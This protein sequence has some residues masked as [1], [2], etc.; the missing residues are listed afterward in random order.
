MN[1]ADLLDRLDACGVRLWL[2]GER[3]RFCGPRGA[4]SP[5]LRDEIKTL[6]P[7]IAALLRRAP[8]TASQRRLWFLERLAPGNPAL[9]MGG[10]FRL[11]GAFSPDRFQA[12]LD[13][14]TARH[15]ALR[16]SIHDDDGEPY[17]LAAETAHLALERTRCGDMNAALAA[18]QEFLVAPFALDVAPLMR[19]A[20]FAVDDDTHLLGCAVHHLIADEWSEGIVLRELSELYGDPQTVLPDL[21][22]DY[23]EFARSRH[24]AAYGKDAWAAIEARV[25]ALRPPLPVLDLSIAGRRPQR[26]DFEGARVSRVIP[27]AL[28]ARLCALARAEGA[29]PFMAL[30]TCFLIV[31]AKYGGGAD[32]L[33]GT[34]TAGRRSGDEAGL[35]G[36]LADTLLLRA[37]LS[38][39]PSFRE[40]LG[41]VRALCL[42]AYAQGEVAFDALVE[43]L[44]P[45]R[46]SSRA[47]LFQAAI[48]LEN[49]PA[50]ALALRGVDVEAIESPR[51]GSQFD[52]ALVLAERPG[53]MTAMV[54]YA[55]ALFTNSAMTRLLGHYIQVLTVA[56][57]APNDAIRGFDLLTDVEREKLRA[58]EQGPPARVRAGSSLHGLFAAQAALTPRAT[59]L[60]MGDATLSYGGLAARAAVLAAELSQRGVGRGAVV[61]VCLPRGFDLVAAILAVLQVG[62]AYLPLDPDYPAARLA[63]MVGETGAAVILTTGALARSPSLLGM[64][65][66]AEF[67]CVDAEMTAAPA[68]FADDV[69]DGALAGIIYT[70]GSTGTPKGVTLSH[71]GLCN[72]ALEQIEAFAI[73]AQSRVLQFAS[74]SFDAAASEIF[75][76]LL[77]GATL[78]LATR[79]RLLTDLVDLLEDERISVATL[80]PALLQLLP[81]RRL[82]D[83]ATLVVAGEACAP[84][85]ARL[86]V[87]GRRFLN[88][89]GPTEGSVCATIAACDGEGDALPIG[90][91]VA[92]M[93]VRIL[94]DGGRRVPIGVEGEIHLAGLPLSPG[95][96]R[97]PDLTAQRFLP[98]PEAPFGRLYATGDLGAWRE[99]GQIDYRGRRDEQIKLRGM[100]IEPAEIATALRAHPDVAEAAIVAHADE[101]AGMRLTAYVVAR[102]GRVADAHA[103]KRWLRERLPAHMIPAALVRL[104]ALPLS[105]NGKLDRAA[106]PKPQA[107]SGPRSVAPR[108]DLEMRLMRMW[109]A[110]LPGQA[111]GVSDDFF[112]IGGHSLLAV[113]L[114]ALIEERLQRSVSLTTLLTHPTIERLAGEL[115]RERTVG[116]WSPLVE[117]RAGSTA[118]PFFCVHPLGGNVWGYRP[119]AARMRPDQGL[120]ALQAPGLE[121]GS[122][123]C[124]SVEALA[125]LYLSA[126]SQVAP[127]G[128]IHLGGHS[129]GGL[130]AFEMARRWQR[131][132]RRV[133]SLVLM[134][135]PAPIDANRPAA[136]SDDGEWLRRRVRVLEA[137]HG[138]A[139]GVA[140][141]DFDKLEPSARIDLFLA[142]LRRGDLLPEEA[143]EAFVR[144][145]LSVQRA[146]H[147]AATSYRP[148]PTPLYDG[149]ILLL[150]A[151]ARRPEAGQEG[152]ARAFSHP[153]LNWDVFCRG[154]IEAH[155][156]PGDH[157]SMLAEPH[158]A[159]I[160][161][162]LSRYWA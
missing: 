37:D 134:D 79:E 114:L 48:V 69:G 59:A 123:P 4:V 86:W 6:R 23:F 44:A 71:A 154:P 119:L 66:A 18:A 129:F 80:P 12:A 142:A 42:E 15:G 136:V 70:S 25:A 98:D 73:T 103:L 17:Q 162:L 29:T 105:P 45:Q 149:N 135:T 144:R 56:V 157:I 40:L 147:L 68:P 76:A 55:T 74:L 24:R 77:S 95:Y 67:V 155:T 109:E 64:P 78:V 92:G 16:V 158:V 3:L 130:V 87:E 152:E 89:Y 51:R 131:A 34:V 120:Y 83:L 7:Q 49:A 60:K 117:L 108:D 31:L 107:D 19:V 126:V 38:G 106:L 9:I 148:D 50:G 28:Y 1:A 102:P 100:R 65:A 52:L 145:L 146:S 54:D 47:H 153:L 22:T 46:D 33:V 101:A 14:L 13:R 127:H 84:E 26:Q 27:D 2:D 133:G 90:R 43:R 93:T 116:A 8:L 72:L 125:D 96:W 160:A 141:G 35:V 10:L 139:L 104:A 94:D 159:D 62:A 128:A 138:V 5:G 121:L 20:A 63:H 112:D 85:T 150:R 32:L 11:K 132:G 140:D 118:V 111:F 143:G 21:P 97:R 156:I 61:G 113:K 99:D 115:R 88:A 53:G 36:C 57:G 82:P 58:L 41:R 39:N 91:P 75:T 81:H 124:E 137:F 161:A 122:A 110:V 151:G 30:A